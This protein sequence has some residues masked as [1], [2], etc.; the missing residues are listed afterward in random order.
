MGE[1]AASQDVATDGELIRR[2][3]WIES[4]CDA[5]NRRHLMI[6]D[7]PARWPDGKQRPYGGLAGSAAIR[8]LTATEIR[9]NNS[10]I[11]EEHAAV[12]RATAA[13]RSSGAAPAS[14]AATPAAP[15][16]A[17]AAAA[18]RAS[19]SPAA[20]AATPA[21]RAPEVNLFS[22]T[23]GAATAAAAALRKMSE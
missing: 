18:G 17:T 1:I 11:E 15:A 22:V 16:P 6:M 13:S 10:M 2:F 4:K 5:L 20:R 7:M 9:W 8:P 21:A 23:P 12:D 3:I 19:R 14:G